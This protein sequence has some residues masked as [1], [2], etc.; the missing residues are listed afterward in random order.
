MIGALAKMEL[1]APAGIQGLE[2][3][4][5]YPTTIYIDRSGVVRHI[6]SGFWILTKPHKEWQLKQMEEHIRLILGLEP[7]NP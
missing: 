5:G 6:H 2:H 7:E 1:D 4:G 3:F